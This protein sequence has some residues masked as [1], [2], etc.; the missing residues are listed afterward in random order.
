M[1]I[2]EVN[3]VIHIFKGDTG[4]IKIAGFNPEINY[5][6]YLQI[7]DENG[8]FIGSQLNQATGGSTQVTFYITSALSDL[9]TIPA[10]EDT[11]TYY[12]GVKKSEVGIGDEDTIIPEF[13]KK[14]LMIVHRK[15]A[16]G[17]ANG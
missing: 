6:V 16:E 10:G 2:K 12:V 3:G 4:H 15:Y 13:G 11:A 1:T 17:P 5:N 9:L 14:K 8:N 7:S